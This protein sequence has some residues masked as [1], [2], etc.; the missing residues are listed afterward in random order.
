MVSVYLTEDKN[1]KSHWLTHQKSKTLSPSIKMM[2]T[3]CFL[4]R[5][6]KRLFLMVQKVINKTGT[7]LWTILNQTQRLCLMPY[8]LQEVRKKR[9][10]RSSKMDFF[11][12]ERWISVWMTHIPVVLV[13]SPGIHPHS[14]I[15][16]LQ[17]VVSI[18]LLDAYSHRNSR[19][20]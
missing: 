13:S 4:N 2:T 10:W 9:L 17:A 16:K 12:R 15:I 20:L 8:L 19:L 18:P 7:R 3:T 6:S 14:I 5:N 11:I 1:L